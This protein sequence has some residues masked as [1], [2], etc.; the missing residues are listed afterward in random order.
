MKTRSRYTAAE[1]QAFALNLARGHY[2]RNILLG[3]QRLSGADLEG[4]AL[5]FSG[6]YK[7]SREALLARLTRAGI[8]WSET[9]GAHGKRILTIA[10]EAV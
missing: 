9:R 5:R 10:G 1:W 8:P 6:I 3:R 4:K 2:Q 7:R